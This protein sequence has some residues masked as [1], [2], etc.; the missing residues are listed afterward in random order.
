MILSQNGNLDP[1]EQY[2]ED[3]H[4]TLL[5]SGSDPKLIDN[6]NLELINLF[7]LNVPKA[8]VAYLG[9]KIFLPLVVMETTIKFW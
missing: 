9:P 8:I 4:V 1:S 3:A 7:V 6:I 2:F 5:N